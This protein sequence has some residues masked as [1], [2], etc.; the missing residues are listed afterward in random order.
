MGI[1]AFSVK[2][3]KDRISRDAI[4]IQYGLYI[5]HSLHCDL[6][7]KLCN[8]QRHSDLNNDI[9]DTLEQLTATF[10]TEVV[11]DL[12]DNSPNDVM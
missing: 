2:Q 12:P 1:K 11:G 3:F 7:R 4:R 9:N 10:T 5:L 8:S 6:V